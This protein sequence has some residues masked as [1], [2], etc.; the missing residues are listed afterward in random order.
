MNRLSATAIII[1]ATLAAV[2]AP[3]DDVRRLYAAGDYAAA[4][5]QARTILRRTPRDGNANYYLGASL[6]AMGNADDARP[7]LLKAQERGVADASRLLAVEALDNYDADAA[8]EYMDKW[9]AA[10]RKAKKS[11]P[12]SYN[13]L[14]RR[15]GR[16]RN[17]LDRVER[18]EIVDSLSVDSAAFFSAY[19]LSASAGSILPA[20]AVRRAGAAGA[21]Q[22][23]S[24]AF[25]PQNRSELLWA[26][27]DTA[28]NYKLYGADI[29]DDGTLDHAEPIDALPEGSLNAA[30]PFLMPDGATL[31]FAADGPESLGGLDIFMTRRNDA[32]GSYFKPQ[33]IGMPYNSPA[34][35]YLL[36][37]DEASGLGWWA[38]DRNAPE[39][40]VTVYVFL[41]SAM[42]VNVDADDPSLSSLARLD[43]ISLTRR[44]D[45]DYAAELSRR[46][47]PTTAA[48]AGTSSPAR[49][50]IDMG[51]G[52]IYTAAGDFASPRARSAMLEALATS[53]ALERHLAAEEALRDRYRRGDRSVAAH[54]IESEAETARL[55]Q[56]LKAQ[57]NS[58]IKLERQ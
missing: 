8:A 38:T 23:V 53:V 9:E 14:S 25:T 6:A 12:D 41:P 10:A 55:R 50:A 58:A 57:Q 54:I 1:L 7:Y 42:R 44:P 34:N 56:L 26:A 30:F 27:T 17:M 40:K 5:G 33:N 19:R 45:T 11:L 28:G 16:M 15:L 52:R 32:D 13:A 39:G 49:F 3:I 43:D 22:D 24:V 21:A 31:Y 18:I 37:I 35:D 47:P 29:L 2:A 51:G 20:D 46:L 36:A 4:A 48:A